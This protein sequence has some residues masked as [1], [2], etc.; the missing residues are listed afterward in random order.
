MAKTNNNTEKVKIITQEDIAQWEDKGCLRAI[1]RINRVLFNQN[2]YVIATSRVEDV[3][4][5]K[6]YYADKNHN[7]TL[8]GH[9][10]KP[11]EGRTY[12]FVGYL[13]PNTGTQSQYPPAYDVY[14][15]GSE[16]NLET[17]QD[18]KNFLAN[19]LT[20][21]QLKIL[22]E[23]ISDP[24]AIIQK[25]DIDTL[26][27]V[28]G[29]GYKLARNIITKYQENITKAALLSFF[30]KYHLNIGSKT[31]SNLIAYYGTAE[32]VLETI[33]NNP[34]QLVEVDG[35]GWRKCDTIALGMGMSPKSMERYKAFCL[36]ILHKKRDETGSTTWSTQ[37]LMETEAIK[38]LGLTNYSKELAKTTLR[39]LAKEGKIYLHTN[40]L[41]CGLI[42]DYYLESRILKEIKRL[43]EAPLLLKKPD[44][45]EEKLQE[46]E[47][48]Q[49]FTFNFEQRKAIEEI[50]NHNVLIITGKAGCVDCDT[51][52]FNGKK[53]KKISEYTKGEQVLQYNIDTQ[54]ATLT[55]PERYIKE[56][57][58][59]FWHFETKYGLN[60]T[61]SDEHCNIIVSSKGKTKKINTIDMITKINNNCFHDKFITTFMYNGNGIKLSKEEIRVMCA[62]ICDGTF[63]SSNPNN[64]TC[65]LHLKKE[66]K[67]N[68]LR[69]ILKQ[70]NIPWREKNSAAVG[71]TDFYFIAPWKEKFFSSKWYNCTNIQ[72]QTI[73]DEILYW[74]GSISQKRKSFSTTN[75]QTADFIQFAFSTIGERATIHTLDRIGQKRKNGYTYKTKEY[76]VYI[77]SRNLCGITTDKRTDHTPTKA[78]KV[79]S[80]DGFKYCFTVPTHALIL[81]RNN[82]IFITG[83]S[84]KT[85]VTNG[86]LNAC[87]GITS[88]LCALSGKAA[89]RI[90]EVSLRPASTI[91][92]LVN[93]NPHGLFVDVVV[94]DEVS[95]VNTDLF[96]NLIWKIP[97]GTKL[98]IMGDIAQLETIGQGNI[99][100]DLMESEEVTVC[101]LEKIHRQA[102]ESGIIPQ[103]LSISE[104]ALIVPPTFTGITTFGKKGDFVI[105]AYSKDYRFRDTD[106]TFPLPVDKVL[107]HWQE[108]FERLDKDITKIAV[109]TPRRSNTVLNAF[110]LN[111]NIQEIYNPCRPEIQQERYEQAVIKRSLDKQEGSVSIQ[112]AE[113]IKNMVYLVFR[114]G[115]RVMVT[116]NDYKAIRPTGLIIEHLMSPDYQS[117]LDYVAPYRAETEIY[118]GY[119][120]TILA[121]NEFGMI[122]DFDFAGEVY[123]PSNKFN[124]VDL[125]Y[126]STVHKYQGSECN[127]VIFGMDSSAFYGISRQMIYTGLTRAKEKCILVT[128]IDALTNGV[129]VNNIRTKFTFLQVFYSKRNGIPVPEIDEEY[130]NMV[131]HRGEFSLQQFIEENGVKGVRF[132]K[133]DKEFVPFEDNFEVFEK[134]EIG[135]P[136]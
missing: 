26:I 31:I 38:E 81:R 113:E 65:R 130:D 10:D 57:C 21:T 119:L 117:Y 80:L 135:L 100:K 90:A 25:Q 104:G 67:K 74:D 11:L 87:E 24:F 128:D 17:P 89:Q 2:G 1:V 32:R 107:R 79:K 61:I 132:Q 59:T 34:Y 109:I 76:T 54:E 48:S 18:K 125:G 102:A 99:L 134:E 64:L 42:E 131:A 69:M 23:T 66:R 20:E 71:Y 83:N 93:S 52:Y 136:F 88:A 5:G 44:D 126:A 62:I 70:A 40:E 27:T 15:L 86:F 6:P 72:L 28:K 105:D 29:I 55:L 41:W 108:E 111:Q 96:F 53:W 124:N 110:D 115:D 63:P 35:I 106:T 14:Y 127:T 12:M 49:N 47:N 3:K 22:Y 92:M 30:E 95:M 58:D 45:F 68:R 75:K 73:C 19:I 91:H 13:M 43:Q 50:F 82:K 97:S 77:T 39:E 122:V 60:Q 37:L 101:R 4:S 112:K 123:I 51:E 56:R 116:K 16:I 114:R 46:I 36:Y 120:G 118:N 121:V 84:G 8:K 98:I 7:I 9:F 103:S 85:S 78:V 33:K 94:L 133:A 129:H